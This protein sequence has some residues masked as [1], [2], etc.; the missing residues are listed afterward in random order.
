M[1]NARAVPAPVPV[2]DGRG[3]GCACAHLVR[4]AYF[5]SCPVC[6]LVAEGRLVMPSMAEVGESRPVIA[7]CLCG[8]EVEGLGVVVEVLG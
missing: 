7:S 3:L 2:V 1:R 4:L 5:L 6:D 8:A